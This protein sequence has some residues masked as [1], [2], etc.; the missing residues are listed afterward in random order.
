M[1]IDLIFKLSLVLK[2]RFL[3]LGNGALFSCL[4]KVDHVSDYSSVSSLYRHRFQI[5]FWS[6]ANCFQVKSSQVME[7][8]EVNKNKE[9]LGFIRQACRQQ[10]LAN[11][12]GFFIDSNISRIYHMPSYDL[13]YQLGYTSE[14]VY[15]HI[16]LTNWCHPELF[17]LVWW[18][19]RFGP[20]RNIFYWLKTDLRALYVKLN[21]NTLKPSIS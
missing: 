12:C 5:I 20:R 1:Q 10:K 2:L 16:N 14:K 21:T 6:F 9:Y 8:T 4:Q 19:R 13:Y 15:C 17:Q 18:I 3:E 7:D 11:K